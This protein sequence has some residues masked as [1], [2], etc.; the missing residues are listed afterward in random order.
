MCGQ[1]VKCHNVT[2]GETQGHDLSFES[3]M[4]LLTKPEVWDDF[5][6][7]DTKNRLNKIYMKKKTDAKQSKQ[8]NDASSRK[9]YSFSGQTKQFKVSQRIL[10]LWDRA[11]SL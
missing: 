4:F 8:I 1:N 10:C 3:L 9:H 2:P 7:Y 6:L 11:S 5:F